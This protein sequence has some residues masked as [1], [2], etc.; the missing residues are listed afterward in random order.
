MKTR[1]ELKAQ[2]EKCVRCGGASNKGSAY[3]THCDNWWSHA[4]SVKNEPAL[5][6]MLRMDP[7]SLAGQRAKI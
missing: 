7:A 2:T 5:W 6:E 1:E 3:C 4:H